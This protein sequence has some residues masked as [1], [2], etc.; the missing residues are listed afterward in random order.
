MP[1]PKELRQLADDVLSRAHAKAAELRRL[2]DEMEAALKGTALEGL[3]TRSIGHTMDTMNTDT[4]PT[5][6]AHRPGVKLSGG[7][8][9]IAALNAGITLR[10]LGEKLG[11]KY[12]AIKMRNLRGLGDAE[13]RKL[14]AKKPYNVP[15]S[16]WPDE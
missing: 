8:Y 16:A 6:P 2:A 5:P 15:A 1:T 12:S 4:T 3:P 14:L 7:P 10:Q 11:M 9:G 13:T